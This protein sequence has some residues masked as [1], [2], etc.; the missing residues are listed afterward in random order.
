L[1]CCALQVW[2][3]QF[4]MSGNDARYL[5]YDFGPNCKLEQVT[6]GSAYYAECGIPS[7]YNR[8]TSCTQQRICL[9]AV[10]SYLGACTVKVD[11]SPDA[12]CTSTT[13]ASTWN[14]QVGESV[15]SMLRWAGELG[16]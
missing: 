3:H 9:R 2:N 4:I 16:I 13:L 6:C 1:T 10:Q 15:N 14:Y 12:A 7:T 5:T 8:S 11:L